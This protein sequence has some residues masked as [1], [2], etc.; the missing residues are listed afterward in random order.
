[1]KERELLF[2][3]VSSVFNHATVT[4]K[5]QKSVLDNRDRAQGRGSVVE[6]YTD[7]FS[8]QT[9]PLVIR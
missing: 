5:D 2:V 8:S 9:S 7:V 3:V 4:S 1:M 6:A